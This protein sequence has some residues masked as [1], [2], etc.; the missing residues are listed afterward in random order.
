MSAEPPASRYNASPEA[1]IAAILAHDGPVLVDLDETLYLRN[2]TEDFIDCARPALLA[3]IL[4]RLLDSLRPW[5]FTGGEQTRDVWRVRL[6][7]T[8]LP[9]TRW[10]WRKR[11]GRLAQRFGNQR[12]IAALK[13]RPDPPIILTAGFEP[14]VAP[15][16][17]ALGFPDARIVAAR[18]HT[19]DDR[20]LGKL[21]TAKAFN[22]VFAQ[23][24]AE[25]P[26]F[27]DG[28]GVP[29]FFAGDSERAKQ[30]AKALIE[31]IGFKA[32]AAGGLKN[33][34]YLEP[35]GGLNISF[36]SGEGQGTP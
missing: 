21:H 35:L 4:L 25:G 12:V 19:F 1:A 30:T 17:A 26:A 13:S 24:L 36:G 32:V 10:R 14:V 23:V 34:R 6:V 3:L 9:W 15:L 18:L 2:S 11:V 8:A 5:R 22:T 28:Q 29:V 20:R 16:V 7:S 33:A 27:A 31:S